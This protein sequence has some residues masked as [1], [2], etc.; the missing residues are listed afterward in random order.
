MK[1]QTKYNVGD[2]IWLIS[3]HD[4]QLKEYE[5]YRIEVDCR[6]GYTNE[7][8]WPLHIQYHCT[9]GIYVTPDGTVIVKEEDAGRVWWKTRDEAV[10]Y[11]TKKIQPL[12]D[13]HSQVQQAKVPNPCGLHT[14]NDLRS[15]YLPQFKSLMGILPKKSTI[16]DALERLFPGPSEQP[17]YN[18][19]RRTSQR[20]AQNFRRA[21]QSKPR[22]RTLSDEADDL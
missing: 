11:I 16:V 12:G 20:S 2:T 22:E 18:E 21:L 5:I 15:P 1:I 9:D 17:D 14:I 10:L 13:R 4:A 19:I 7:D 3:A 8:Y 6:G